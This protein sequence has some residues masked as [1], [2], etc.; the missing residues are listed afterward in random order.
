MSK[1]VLLVRSNPYDFDPSSYNVQEIGMGKA[2]CEMGY[3]FDFVTFKKKNCKEWTFYEE[4]GCIARWIEKPRLRFFRWGLNAEV[5][6]KYF[7]EKYDIVICREYYQYLT[8]RITMNC[9][10]VVIYNGPYWN[11]FM[12]KPFSIIYDKLFT[13]KI[14]NRVK[15]I[16][17]KSELATEYLRKKG[18]SK[19]E[20]VGVGLDIS[21]FSTAIKIAEDTEKLVEYM[22]R[23]DCI[24]YVG[25]VDRNKNYE[26]MLNVYKEVKKNKPNT[27]FVVIGKSKQDAF[28][29]ILGMK[30]ET[31]EEKCLEKCDETTKSGIVRIQR[32]DNEQLRFIYPLARAF[33]LPSKREI[34]GMVMLEAMYLGAPVISSRNGG[35]TTLIKNGITGIMIDDYSTNKW[36]TE[37]CHLM[38]DEHLRTTIINNARNL[39]ENEFNWKRIDEKIL[40]CAGEK[41]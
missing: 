17:N 11:M 27:K 14:D 29:K 40:R 32:L 31:Y 39:I 37:I 38:E 20:T 4:N 22:S 7:L 5:C 8:Y 41:V 2:F 13:K 21:R 23:N 9:S 18:Y 24:L 3:N 19:L 15:K 34:F 6:S 10:N 16:I 25:T 36:A 33:I 28:H 26:F 35:S 1:K 30:N 12:V